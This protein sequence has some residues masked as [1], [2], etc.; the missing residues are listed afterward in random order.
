M[1]ERTCIVCRNKGNANKFF[2]MVVGP[3]SH[4][5][6]ELGRK[7]PGRGAHCC[8]HMGCISKLIS[9]NRLRIALKTRD[10]KIDLDVLVRNVRM[11]LIQNLKGMLVAARK[12]GVIS[13]GKE[14]VFKKLKFSKRGKPFVS[15]DISSKSLMNLKRVSEEFHVLPFDMNELGAFLRRK[16]IG[17]LLIDEPLL[18]DSIWLRL[19]QER[20]IS[21]GN[22]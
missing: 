2:R 13:Y 7:L 10:F 14:A 17:V 22:G 9:S 15:K 4:I 11:L 12:K 21:N 20:E 6:C 16:P 18:V 3:D 19:I 5:V 1:P 8:F